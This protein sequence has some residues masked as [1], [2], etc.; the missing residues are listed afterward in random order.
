MIYRKISA[1]IVED[2]GILLDPE[3]KIF[4]EGF[5]YIDLGKIGLPVT[6]PVEWLKYESKMPANEFFNNTENSAAGDKG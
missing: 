3:D 2:R 4:A 6:F 1:V 5:K